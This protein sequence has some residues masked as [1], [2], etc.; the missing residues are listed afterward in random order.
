MV[1]VLLR[2]SQKAFVIRG[3]RFW[4]SMLVGESPC[5]RV[6]T[7]AAL[8][9]VSAGGVMQSLIG[10]SSWMILA[11]IVAEYGSAAVAGYTIAIRVII[12]TIMPAWE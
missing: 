10:T 2:M 4:W 6:V 3:A 11:R 9:R 1:C 5:F 8:L 7:S 12:F